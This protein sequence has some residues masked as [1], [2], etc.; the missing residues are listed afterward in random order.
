MQILATFCKISKNLQV[1]FISKSKKMEE[2][3]FKYG[4]TV[5]T[6]ESVLNHKSA[7]TL[8]VCSYYKAGAITPSFAVFRKAAGKMVPTK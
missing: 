6:I 2:K 3:K 1:L 8:Y 4:K 5:Y 7:G